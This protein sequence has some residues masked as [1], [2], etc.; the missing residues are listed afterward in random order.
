MSFATVGSS[1]LYY[2]KESCPCKPVPPSSAEQ[3][4]KKKKKKKKER[5]NE[6]NRPTEAREIDA[7]TKGENEEIMQRYT[8]S[9]PRIQSLSGLLLR[10]SP[11]FTFLLFL[12]CSGSSGRCQTLRDRVIMRVAL[13]HICICLPLSQRSRNVMLRF[14]HA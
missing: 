3:R 9:P 6:A 1:R 14:L 7:N 13:S 10:S 2:F 5:S 11:L 8:C 4:Q 12:T